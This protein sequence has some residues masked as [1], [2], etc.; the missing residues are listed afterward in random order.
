MLACFSVVFVIVFGL[1]VVCPAAVDE[2][3]FDLLDGSVLFIVM[4]G[5]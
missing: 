4:V 5:P 2:V 1:V 3:L